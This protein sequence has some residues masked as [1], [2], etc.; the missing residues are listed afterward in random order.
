M[1]LRERI[2]KEQ[3]AL[4]AA[5]LPEFDILPALKHRGFSGG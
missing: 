3:R 4:A 1:R 5:R 2:E